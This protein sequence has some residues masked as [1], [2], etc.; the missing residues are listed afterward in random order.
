MLIM[1][2]S[3]C[4]CCQRDKTQLYINHDDCVQCVHGLLHLS[5]SHSNLNIQYLQK[6]N[7]RELQLHLGETSIDWSFKLLI[8]TSNSQENIFLSLNFYVY[9]YI[10]LLF[11]KIKKTN[12]YST[13]STFIPLY[14][15]KNNG[16]VIIS[17]RAPPI[18]NINVQ[19][20]VHWIDRPGLCPLK[21]HDLTSI[22][23]IL[24]GFF[25]SEL[26]T[27]FQ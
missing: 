20:A 15:R 24:L 23:L 4:R 7:E 12:L 3:M 13:I 19:E 8:N 10:F 26:L 5:I 17:D 2:S 11:N 16:N 6:S 27:F 25:I 14:V 22:D 18:Y 21:S 9:K 1:N